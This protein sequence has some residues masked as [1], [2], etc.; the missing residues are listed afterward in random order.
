MKVIDS[1]IMTLKPGELQL[2]ETEETNEDE[3]FRINTRF[4]QMEKFIN[5]SKKSAFGTPIRMG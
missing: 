2:L 3:A 1:K 5:I 4:R